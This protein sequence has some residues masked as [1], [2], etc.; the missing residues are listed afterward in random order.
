MRIMAGFTLP[1]FRSLLLFFNNLR[2]NAMHDSFETGINFF[3]GG[4]YFEAHEV[5]E[6]MWR[7]TRGPLR[8]FYQG[9]VQA[10]VGL[11]HLRQGNLNGAAAQL[12]KSLSKLEQYPEKFC[13]ID[14]GKLTADLRKVLDTMTPQPVRIETV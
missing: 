2:P 3:N 13:R 12:Q 9:L 10:A 5:W 1:V 14:N 11:H 6:D 8:L 4:R 7:S